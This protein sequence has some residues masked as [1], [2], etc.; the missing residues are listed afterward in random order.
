MGRRAGRARAG[1]GTAASARSAP[2][3]HASART[4]SLAWTRRPSPG[5]PAV[6][7]ARQA[8]PG[9]EPECRVARPAT[10]RREGPG[11]VER[12][13]VGEGRAGHAG[14]LSRFRD[15]VTTRAETRRT[16]DRWYGC[17]DVRHPRVVASVALIA[18]A[19]HRRRPRSGRVA[20]PQP[21]RPA[22][23][24]SLPR[25]EMAAAVRGTAMT[26]EPLDPG[27]RSDGILDPGSTM[28]EPTHA[29]EPPQARPGAALP[30]AT[31]KSIAPQ[32]VAHRST[33]CRGTA[34]A[35]TATAPR[36]ADA[37]QAPR[38]RGPSDAAVRHPHR[39]PQPGATAAMVTAAVVD[40]GPF[41]NGR[42]WDLSHGLCDKL[43]H[44][45]TG[46]MQ[47][48]YGKAG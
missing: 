38:R 18:A 24:R 30:K 22:G 2:G 43:D 48:R 6:R 39:V 31:A 4:W 12:P 29:T 26:T 33:T 36:A 44:C 37:D 23:R 21:V 15:S 41:V 3:P 25:A 11:E 34:R 28:F 16:A 8:R 35:S 32:P 13:V 5:R 20:G 9:A 1:A 47:W 19:C 40:R 17:L 7:V 10:E 42:V 45:Y 14:S 27:A 46:T